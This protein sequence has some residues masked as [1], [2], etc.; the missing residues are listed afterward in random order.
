MRKCIICLLALLGIFS[1]CYAQQTEIDYTGLSKREERHLRRLYKDYDYMYGKHGYFGQ[2]SVDATYCIFNNYPIY[3]AIFGLDVVNGYS[4]GPNFDLGAGVGFYH[5][6]VNTDGHKPFCATPIFGYTRVNFI[7][8]KV[9]PYI[10]AK[11]G[12]GYIW[13]SDH[14]S[15]YGCMVREGF[16]TYISTEAGVKV[17]LKSGMALTAGLTWSSLPLSNFGMGL[18]IGFTW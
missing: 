3:D 1:T 7:R 13:D 16:S 18:N 4:F 17:H 8:R 10:A 6:S 15:K 2:V 12:F 11:L 14:N 9:T 5:L